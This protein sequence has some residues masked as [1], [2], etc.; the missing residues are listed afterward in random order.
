MRLNRRQFT[1]ELKRQ[2]LHGIEAGKP[3]AQAAREYQL[4]PGLITKWRLAHREYAQRAFAG[5]ENRY[6]DEA[7]I[8]ELERLVGQLAMENALLKSLAAAR[9]ATPPTERGWRQRM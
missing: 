3:L 5:N 2:F 9:G 4:H 6:R 8:G 1:R 7:R